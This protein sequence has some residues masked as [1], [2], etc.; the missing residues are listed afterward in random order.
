MTGDHPNDGDASG[1]RCREGVEREGELKLTGT[2]CN[3][4]DGGG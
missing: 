1:A 4:A 3:D 2:S